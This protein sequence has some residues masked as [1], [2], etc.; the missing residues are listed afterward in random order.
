MNRVDLGGGAEVTEMRNLDGNDSTLSLD[1][2][3]F[4]ALHPSR[5]QVVK[6]T[7]QV[8]QSVY[9]NGKLLPFHQTDK[10]QWHWD[11]REAGGFMSG[12]TNWI[13]SLEDKGLEDMAW[14]I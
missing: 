4:C 3:L 7:K 13:T 5:N 9:I 8:C 11:V 1:T 12:T 6:W 14:A 10:L 2:L